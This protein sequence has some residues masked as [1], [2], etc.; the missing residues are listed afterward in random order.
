MY[1][2]IKFN[3]FWE[4]YVVFS[5]T[6]NRWN[7]TVGTISK[8][9]FGLMHKPPVGDWLISKKNHKS[10]ITIKVISCS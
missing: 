1:K 6:L 8:Y 4:A 5:P 3:I 2:K 9:F 10:I 7:A